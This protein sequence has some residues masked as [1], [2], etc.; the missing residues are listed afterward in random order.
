MEKF[1][2]VKVT[3]KGVVGA[4]TCELYFYRTRE[5]AREHLQSFRENPNYLF[6]KGWDEADEIMMFNRN[7]HTK[8]HIVLTECYFED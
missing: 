8:K 7:T 6:D 3:I 2:C 4:E 5:K 1:Y